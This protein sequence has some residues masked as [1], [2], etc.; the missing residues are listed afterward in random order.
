MR[1]PLELAVGP[2]LLALVSAALGSLALFAIAVGLGVVYIGAHIAVKKTAQ[3]LVVLRT[4]DRLEVVEGHPITLTFQVG[5]FSGLPAGL[6]VLVEHGTWL[7]L[8]IGSSSVTWAID[9]PGRHLL[10]P[11]LL[12]IRDDLGLFT[13]LVA[14]GEPQEVLVLPAPAPQVAALDRRG[15]LDAAHDPEPDGV[16]PYVRGTPMSRIH[17]AS[18]ARG[19]ELQERAFTTA[20]DHL[21]LVVVDTVGDP[22]GPAVDWAARVAAGHVLALARGGGCRVLLPGDASPVTLKDPITQWP[23]VHRRLA[24]LGRGAPAVPQRS[25]DLRSAVQVSALAAPTDALLARGA[26]PPGVEA[27]G[28]W[29][30]A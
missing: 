9:R 6:E 5:G 4:V 17:W 10:G 27:I 2:I 21:P 23:A 28:E 13:H 11:S 8:P 1:R 24:A 12:R 16:R 7:R 14:V 29:A 19:G 25:I 26:L 22:T 3:R 20:R 15:A 30:S 18:A